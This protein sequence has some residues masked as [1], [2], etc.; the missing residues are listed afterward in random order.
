MS[1]INNNKEGI[2]MEPT[3]DTVEYF[4]S[5]YQRLDL[6]HKNIAVVKKYI[7]RKRIFEANKISNLVIMAVVWTS[8]KLEEYLT[9]T[10][11]LVLLGS[12]KEVESSTVMTLDPELSSMSLLDLMDAVGK[13]YD[14]K[15]K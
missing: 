3:K 10:D 6:Y 11:V 12:D 15:Y 5:V 8:I 2:D 7:S 1:K 4:R 14:E 9:E 13:A